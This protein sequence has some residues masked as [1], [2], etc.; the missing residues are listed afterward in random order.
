MDHII[1]EI[2][3]YAGMALIITSF[4]FGNVIRLRI[5]NAIGGCLSAVYGFLTKTYPTAILNIVLVIINIIMIVY[6][7]NFK[8]KKKKQKEINNE[9][10]SING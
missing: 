1:T 7:L 10:N 2:L 5:L 9:S 8:K 3:G 6:I 4:L